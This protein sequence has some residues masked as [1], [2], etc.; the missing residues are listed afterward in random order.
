M[1]TGLPCRFAKAVLAPCMLS[2][3]LSSAGHHDAVLGAA[4]MCLLWWLPA[5]QVVQETD[6]REVYACTPHKC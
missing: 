6:V 2:P 5:Q 1:L 3:C 4:E